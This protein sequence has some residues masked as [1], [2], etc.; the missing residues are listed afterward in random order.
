MLVDVTQTQPTSA[1]PTLATAAIRRSTAP[2]RHVKTTI[3][4]EVSRA[5]S[6]VIVNIH[7]QFPEIGDDGG[8]IT[9]TD[10]VRS[11]GKCGLENPLEDGSPSQCDPNSADFC[12]S[13]YGYCGGSDAH[14]N[15]ETCMNYKPTGVS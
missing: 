7:I 10:G 15:C 2:V 11:D 6:Y 3:P 9:V 5:D 12:C 4:R 14:C 1:A 13:A 8:N